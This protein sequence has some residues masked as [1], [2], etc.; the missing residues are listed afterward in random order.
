MRKE[1]KALKDY[2]AAVAILFAHSQLS[3]MATSVHYIGARQHVWHDVQLLQ[4]TV[5]VCQVRNRKHLSNTG[6]NFISD[7]AS[8]RT[9]RA[10]DDVCLPPRYTGALT[11][12]F[13]FSKRYISLQYYLT[14]AA[15][16]K[17]TLNVTRAYS[18]TFSEGH[19]F[20]TRVKSLYRTDEVA[21]SLR[22]L[23]TVQ[24]H[25]FTICS[26]RGESEIRLGRRCVELSMK[27][28]LGGSQ[29]RRRR[30][31]SSQTNHASAIT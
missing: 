1:V 9:R 10:R 6:T 7:G 15:D 26:N 27:C 14:V 20:C 23:L 13:R 2:N 25:T 8:F 21:F 31:S 3:A 19:I 29:L 12:D 4:T 11:H 5:D 16:F 28:Y 22:K 17:E 24:V 30:D 18:D